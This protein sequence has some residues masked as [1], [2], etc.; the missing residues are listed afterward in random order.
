[1][2]FDSEMQRPSLVISSEFCFTYGYKLATATLALEKKKG[3]V[4]FPDNSN[5]NSVAESA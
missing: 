4:G 3:Q 1:M 5:K 2:C